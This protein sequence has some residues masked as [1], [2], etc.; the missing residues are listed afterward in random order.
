[1]RGEGFEPVENPFGFS[2]HSNYRSSA[3]E[4]LRGNESSLFRDFGK[5]SPVHDISN[6][7]E[8]IERFRQFLR[9]KKNL[10][11]RTVKGHCNK[12][13]RFLHS[14]HGVLSAQTVEALLSRVKEKRKPKTYAN[15]LCSFK[16][17]VRDFKGLS[18]M[19]DYEFPTIIEQPII[20]PSKEELHS[21][22]DA[23]PD[24]KRTVDN[25][26]T[27]EPKYKALFL[28]LASSGLRIG[29]AISLRKSDVDVEKRMLIP[30]SH[31][32]NTTK[33]AWVS[34]YNRETDEYLTWI[35]E[36]KPADLIFPTDK[37]VYKAFITA[38]HISDIHITPQIL[39]K[40][41]CEEMGILGVGDRYIDA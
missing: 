22:F 3:S 23:L 34:F 32:T 7:E 41:F 16:R 40:W 26:W 30:K 11:R 27:P 38:R 15:Y 6:I 25:R 17:Y 13:D 9:L 10:S 5:A 33:R 4:A 24:A 29:E 19:D 18:Y 8:E 37:S 36:L 35:H 2:R 28:L 39:R 20:V 21:F 12:I 14:Y 31:E 1:M